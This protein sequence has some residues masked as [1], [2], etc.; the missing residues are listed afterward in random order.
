MRGPHPLR[1]G[2]G[3]LVLAIE[4]ATALAPGARAQSLISDYPVP[5]GWFYSQEGRTPHDSPR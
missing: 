4:M 3:V 5:G 1:L 2:L